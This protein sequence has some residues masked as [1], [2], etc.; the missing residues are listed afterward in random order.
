MG[1]NVNQADGKVLGNT[2]YLA[3]LIQKNTNADIFRIESKIPYSTDHR[4]LIDVARKE[5]EK[6]TRPELLKNVE[7][8]EQY[9]VIFLGYPN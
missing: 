5:K 2:Q 6:K 8:I 1:L 7:N 4:T 3:M 9:D